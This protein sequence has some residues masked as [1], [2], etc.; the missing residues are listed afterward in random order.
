MLLCFVCEDPL[1]SV[2]FSYLGNP[3]VRASS[4]GDLCLST[5]PFVEDGSFYSRCGGLRGCG[6]LGGCANGYPCSSA[7]LSRSRDGGAG[8]LRL[9]G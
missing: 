3:R 2:K 5:P 1:V 8:G 4:S 7:V 9:A 6:V